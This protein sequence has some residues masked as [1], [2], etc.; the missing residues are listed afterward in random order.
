LSTQ[1]GVKNIS[2]E[3]ISRL[4]PRKCLTRPKQLWI[5]S[6]SQERLGKEFAFTR[7]I[8]C[9]ICGSS[10]SA[11]EKFKNL[12]DGSIAKY[13]YY[14]C[15]KSKDRAC[16]GNYIK[17]DLLVGQ[18]LKVI[19]EVDLDKLGIKQQIEQKLESYNKFRHLSIRAEPAGATTTEKSGP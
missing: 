8:T 18:L 15:N 13:I 3:S 12:K 9:G 17:E 7:L 1:E 5:P 11:N 14:C 4:L 10:I 19:E 6:L 2:R 16:P